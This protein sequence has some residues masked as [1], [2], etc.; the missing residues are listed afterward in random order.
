[1]SGNPKSRATVEPAWLSGGGSSESDT[2]S[3]KQATQSSMVAGASQ[4]K[5]EPS[6]PK[7]EPKKPMFVPKVPVKKEAP[8]TSASSARY[9]RILILVVP[10]PTLKFCTFCLHSFSAA[11]N[12]DKNKQESKSNGDKGKKNGGKAF[13][14]NKFTPKAKS[15]G[16]ADKQQQGNRKWV[17]PVGAAFFTGSNATGG[18]APVAAS[19][20]DKT[21]IAAPTAGKAAINANGA[22]RIMR[23]NEVIEEVR[24]RVPH[25]AKCL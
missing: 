1:M 23:P 5:N 17:M 10:G 19:A 16:F 2:T 12:L 24:D 14:V 22:T 8:A 25:T 7:F 13:T 20:S 21:V 9:D 6:Q 3:S 11:T 4:V 18:A 15:V